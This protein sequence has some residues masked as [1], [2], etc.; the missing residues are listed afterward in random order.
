MNPI[1]VRRLLIASAFVFF[2]F[3]ASRIAV[4]NDFP[5]LVSEPALLETPKEKPKFEDYGR[6]R[7][8]DYLTACIE[9]NTVPELIWTFWFGPKGMSENR[10]KAFSTMQE[11]LVVPV[12]LLTDKNVSDFL[13]WPV[14]P[15]VHFLSGIHRAD[16]FR[17]YFMYHYGG[18]YTD[19][20]N[21]GE[22]WVPFFKEFDD[23]NVWMVGVP[24]IKGGVAWMPGPKWPGDDYY[25]KMISNCFMISRPNNQLL[26]EV[27]EMQNDILNKKVDDLIAHPPPDPGRCC[28]GIDPKGYPIR[29]AELLG[30]LM[31]FVGQKY[32]MHFSRVMK[33]PAIGNYV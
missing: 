18:G 33:F 10:H 28:Q 1:L 25:K 19:V 30:E 15:Y 6:E 11:R 22:S 21:M 32:Y 5:N 20:K 16:Y 14:N 17:I 24:E 3:I 26:K 13:R 29:W 7:L 31:A 8:Q 2:I 9:T 27:H 4:R 12:I 23:P